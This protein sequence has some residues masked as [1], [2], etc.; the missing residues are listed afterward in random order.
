MA[1]EPGAVSPGSDHGRTPNS[2]TGRSVRD[3]LLS[4]RSIPVNMTTDPAA[5]ERI[6]V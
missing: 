4:A 2:G 6:T 1:R 5:P 3:K